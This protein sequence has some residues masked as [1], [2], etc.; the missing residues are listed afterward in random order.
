MYVID[1]EYMMQ[2]N[3]DRF[4]DIGSFFGRQLYQEYRTTQNFTP[5][6][7]VREIILIYCAEIK[8]H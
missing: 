4:D 2:M 3:F 1:S 6:V 7:K 8:K 5:D